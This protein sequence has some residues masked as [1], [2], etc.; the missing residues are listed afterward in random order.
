MPKHFLF[1]YPERLFHLFW[2]E[3]VVSRANE[4]TGV[5]G[6]NDLTTTNRKTSMASITCGPSRANHNSN[7]H[8]RYSK[9]T[10]ESLGFQ[11]FAGLSIFHVRLD[12][13]LL[14]YYNRNIFKMQWYTCT[15]AKSCL[16]GCVIYHLFCCFVCVFENRDLSSANPSQIVLDIK[17]IL[18]AV[19]VVMLLSARPKEN[20][21]SDQYVCWEN[22]YFVRKVRI[23]TFLE[24]SYAK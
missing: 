8:C 22:I 9:C 24:L 5:P 4:Q 13:P 17:S 14:I 2:A 10:N 1:F 23:G 7:S 12:L 3:F 6:V 11:T 20:K 15:K 21:D 16:F 18:S 19:T